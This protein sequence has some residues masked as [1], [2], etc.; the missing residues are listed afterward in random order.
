MFKCLNI[1][2]KLD[3]TQFFY[4]LKTHIDT[5]KRHAISRVG[6]IGNVSHLVQ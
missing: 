3:Y 5:K 1:L 6:A 4:D 2:I